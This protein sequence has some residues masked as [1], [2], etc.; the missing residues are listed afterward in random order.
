MKIKIFKID[1]STMIISLPEGEIVIRGNYGEG[2]GVEE[3][4]GKLLANT[5]EDF[6]EKEM[7]I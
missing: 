7:E 3:T 6:S 5:E 1:D 4:S 2:F